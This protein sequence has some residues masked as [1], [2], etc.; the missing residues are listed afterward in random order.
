MGGSIGGGQGHCASSHY[1]P[2]A[3]PN[4]IWLRFSSTILQEQF[5]NHL[6]MFCLAVSYFNLVVHHYV[7]H[8]S[9]SCIAAIPL[10]LY[11]PSLFLATALLASGIH[12]GAIHS[13]THK[14]VAMDRVFATVLNIHHPMQHH[15]HDRVQ[16]KKGGGHQRPWC[17]FPVPW[18]KEWS[19]PCS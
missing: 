5:Y 14:N 2:S 8:T 19:L 7:M 6:A 13:D 3:T 11:T 10:D 16:L 15:I 1:Q 4:S 9:Y 18:D 17:I 12:P